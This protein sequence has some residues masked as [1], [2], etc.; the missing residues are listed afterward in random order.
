MQKHHI[1]N[2]DLYLLMLVF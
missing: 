2:Q 1:Y